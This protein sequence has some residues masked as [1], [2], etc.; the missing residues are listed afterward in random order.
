MGLLFALVASVA[1]A[2]ESVSTPDIQVYKRA[3]MLELKAHLFFPPKVAGAAARPAMVLFHGGGWNAGAPEWVYASAQRFAALGMVTMAVQYRLS[4]EKTTTPLDAMEDAKDA[5]RWLRAHAKVFNVDAD[6]VAAYGVSAGGQL[7]AMAAVGDTLKDGLSSAPNAL[8]LYSP[9]VAVTG[10]GWMRK[11]LMGR[12]TPEQVSPD[13]S[14]RAGLP[15]VHI[16]QGSEDTT[17]PAFGARIYCA[18]LREAGNHCEVNGLSGLGHLLS[19]KLDE[20]EFTF[21]ADPVARDH[22]YRAQEKFLACLGYIAAPLTPAFDSPE[23]VVRAQVDA[24]NARDVEAMA[25]YVAEDFVWYN[26][27]ADKMEIESKGRAALRAGME[28]YFRGNPT[29]R[30]EIHMVATNGNFVFTRERATWKT[31]AGEERSQNAFAI[32]E[33][34]AGLIK[35]VWYYPAQK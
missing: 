16:S 13:Q 4:D 3:G 14:A 7:A 11:L 10:S 23:T 34:S 20:Q 17:T 30:S 33:V 5:I 19:R 12:A 25:R 22:A 15:P 18:R 27:V 1:L 32:Y 9:A 29:A 31:K 24:F 26:V 2:Q 6:R 28:R 8:V 21:D 35:R